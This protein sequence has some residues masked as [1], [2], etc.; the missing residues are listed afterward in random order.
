MIQRVMDHVKEQQM[1]EE[2]DCVVAGV[3]GGA[4]S[5][6]LLLMLLEIKKEIA[7]D[8]RVVHVDHKIRSDSADD[9]AYVAGLCRAHG[10]P[11]VL[12][13]EDVGALARERHISVEEAGRDV[14]YRAFFDALGEKKGKIAIAHNK[15]DS[16]ETF[17]FHLFR[18]TSLRGLGGILPVRGQIIRPLLCL[19]RAQIERFLEERGVRYCIDSTNLED[20]H[21]RNRI[22]HHILDAAVREI[23]PAAVGHISDACA[24]IHGAFQLI[25]EL[26]IQGAASCVATDERGRYH[27]EEEPFL[28]LHGT[29]QGYVLMEALSR[30]AGSRKDLGAV[31]IAQLKELM[32]KQCGR[33]ID[34]PCGLVAKRGYDGICIGKK[35]AGQDA[36]SLEAVFTRR[37]QESLLDGGSVDIILNDRQ[38][39]RATIMRRESVDLKNIPEKKYTKWLDHD[40]IKD[41]IVIRTRRPGDYLTVNAM[42]Q[43][44]TLKSYFID[45]KVPQEERGCIFLVAEASHIIWVIGGRISS[46]YKVTER[47]QR[48]LCLSWIDEDMGGEEHPV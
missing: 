29:I 2:G 21:T 41:N 19:E 16:C 46:H 22:R 18:G 23:S 30:A 9:A 12:V 24:Q 33:S 43:R 37:E 7:I 47:T 5:V 1:L 36:R 42:D 14:R 17:L 10:I 3:S 26:T 25:E 32:G 11:F 48:I 39:L 27:I 13:E 31:H 45:R 20:H 8:I 38:R 15:N 6:C 35:D 44:K 28:Q 4:D 40:T 34:L